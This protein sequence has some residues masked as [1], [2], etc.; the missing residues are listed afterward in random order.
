[1]S[2]LGPRT[3]PTYNGS[4]P[5]NYVAGGI[6]RGAQ[7]FTTRSD[8]GPARA[9]VPVAG[10]AAPGLAGVGLLFLAAHSLRAVWAQMAGW[11]CS[12]GGQAPRQISM[13]LVE[14]EEWVC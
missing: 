4:M 5:N 1:M 10:T 14:V 2:G 3:A 8:I 11:L 6:G 9:A 7:G 12:S 13:L